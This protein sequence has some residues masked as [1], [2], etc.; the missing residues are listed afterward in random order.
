MVKALHDGAND[1]EKFEE[2]QGFTSFFSTQHDLHV[3]QLIL[4]QIQGK[5]DKLFSPKRMRSKSVCS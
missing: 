5:F 1:D 4:N 2:S 3:Q